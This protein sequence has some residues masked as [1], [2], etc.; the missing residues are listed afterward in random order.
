M[1]SGQ[2]SLGR[3]G[4]RKAAMR[5]VAPVSGLEAPSYLLWPLGGHAK[6]LPVKTEQRS[7]WSQAS[8]HALASN[9]PTPQ[10]RTP[11]RRFWDEVTPVNVAISCSSE[12]G[13]IIA[14]AQ[15]AHSHPPSSVF[16]WKPPFG[17]VFQRPA[18]TLKDT[19]GQHKLV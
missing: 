5:Y 2:G 16:W 19:E 12:L 3:D 10:P 17:F 1:A 18:F 14:P 4:G 13:T 15:P 7:M 8:F 9:P 6:N 11:G